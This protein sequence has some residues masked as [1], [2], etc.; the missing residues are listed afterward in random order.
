MSAH[1]FQRHFSPV[2][3]R[4]FYS[5]E[6][7]IDPP[8]CPL[9]TCYPLNEEPEATV[10]QPSTGEEPHQL[11]GSSSSA[12]PG[13]IRTALGLSLTK[14]RV[15]EEL[16]REHVRADFKHGISFSKQNQKI[17]DEVIARVPEIR[18]EAQTKALKQLLRLESI[19]FN[20][21][22]TPNRVDPLPHTQQRLVYP[23]KD[24]D[25]DSSLSDCDSD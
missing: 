12:M 7:V 24:T 19:A 8:S 18:L 6:R 14:L 2:P 1:K 4:H 25:T 9:R 13:N 3:L 17:I 23:A 10:T 11:G 15:L 16:V 21:D 5:V 20:R 22:A